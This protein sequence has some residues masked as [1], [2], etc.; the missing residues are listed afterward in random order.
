[1]KEKNIEVVSSSRIRFE[2]LEEAVRGKVQDWLQDILAEE[3]RDFLGREKHE[4]FGD[5]LDLSSGY[6]NGYGKPRK[7]SLMSGTITVRRPRVRGLEER[8]ESQVLPLFKRQSEEIRMM[9]PELYLHGLAKGDFELALRG[10]LGEG[11]PLSPASIGRLKAKWKL[12]HEE[13]RKAD[14][15]EVEVVY[16][17]ADGIYVKAGLE[18]HKAALLVIIG[19]LSS[20][21]KIILACESGQRESK[22]NWASILRDLKARGLKLPR[23]TIADGHL[24][25]WAALGEHHPQGEEQRC[26]NHK[27]VNV[28]D[29]LPK[30][31]QDE[32]K[33][34][35]KTMPYEET[36]A[37]CEKKRDQF[38]LRYKKDYPKATEK[39]MRDWERMIT[40]Y[41]FPKEHW[42]HLRTTNIVE[43]PFAAVRL[44]TSAS[45]RYKKVESATAMIWK[46][47]KVAEKSFR[48]INSP[49]MLP[50]VY[51]G[52]LFENGIAVTTK[53]EDLKVA[54]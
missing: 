8:F 28:L 47:L 19:A 4:R 46:L 44:R 50:A 16:Q 48:K 53:T 27:I 20:G 31:L 33:E 32:A 26:W 9:L 40:F 2:G 41:S 36:K 7:L 17:W 3:V 6:R 34:L 21:Q 35:L 12:E 13:W 37:L 1:M 15:S 45:K 18:D 30:K 54:A 42:I 25:I 22:E 29:A 11:A 10:L 51:A 43:S 5:R 49:E 24:G 23:L 14:L 52:K 38:I 39:L